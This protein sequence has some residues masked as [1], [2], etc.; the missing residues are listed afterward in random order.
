MALRELK[1]AGNRA[2]AL[3]FINRMKKKI[4]FS[5]YSE[6]KYDELSNKLIEIATE[7]KT[8]REKINNS[9]DLDERYNLQI[10]L[11]NYIVKQRYVMYERVLVN[12]IINLERSFENNKG[13]YGA[14]APLSKQAKIEQLIKESKYFAKLLSSI[15]ILDDDLL[16]EDALDDSFYDIKNYLQQ[17]DNSIQN[18]V[19]K[20]IGDNELIEM[21]KNVS[22]TFDGLKEK[23]QE[24]L[25]EPLK[26]RLQEC[27][28]Q[29]N[30]SEANKGLKKKL[31]QKKQFDSESLQNLQT[32]FSHALHKCNRPL[33]ITNYRDSEF[34]NLNLDNKVLDGFF[35]TKSIDE[36]RYIQDVN[37]KRLLPIFNST[38]ATDALNKLSLLDIYYHYILEI[39]NKLPKNF[40]VGVHTYDIDS[41][42]EK[43]N[44]LLN[45]IELLKEKYKEQLKESNF[46]S[47]KDAVEAALECQK[48]YSSLSKI[49]TSSTSINSKE[50]KLDIERLNA[51][52]SKNYDILLK[53][54]IKNGKK[55]DSDQKIKTEETTRT[56]DLESENEKIDEEIPTNVIEDEENIESLDSNVKG[57]NESIDLTQHQD[58]LSITLNNS[59]KEFYMKIAD[60]VVVYRNEYQQLRVRG[61]DITFKE[62][63]QRKGQ[64]D[65]VEIEEY[66]EKLLGRLLDVYVKSNSELSFSEFVKS[67]SNLKKLIS[68]F[69]SDSEL[70]EYEKNN[71]NIKRL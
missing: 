70:D 24:E 37:L 4:G 28:K 56:T 29:F 13:Y 48:A 15:D 14:F 31:T 53:I 64:K 35:V 61:L 59:M 60:N 2:A 65:I 9:K 21:I 5:D 47:Y 55:I 66:K 68:N 25:Y 11:A 32:A 16:K 23:V 39:K 38:K 58:M 44:E 34:I 42:F 22:K 7:I 49:L 46:E 17:I 20:Q 43:L 18:P 12:Q 1:T 52:Y 45:H 19:V 30:I 36:S 69:I 57:N 50:V 41:V 6:K 51:T 54:A 27:I 26:N 71:K 62:F 8:L 40:N 67:D 33:Y 10:K 3:D 63:C